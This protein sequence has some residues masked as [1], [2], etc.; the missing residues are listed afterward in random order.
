MPKWTSPILTLSRRPFPG[1]EQYLREYSLWI[2]V[3]STS[4][5]F[6]ALGVLFR[7][8]F[9]IW[10]FFLVFSP[11]SLFSSVTIVLCSVFFDEPKCYALTFFLIDFCCGTGLY[12]M[13]DGGYMV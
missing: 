6:L 3:L 7:G 2:R 10:S 5:L 11:L 4:C 12:K 8:G 9:G 13:G 1:R